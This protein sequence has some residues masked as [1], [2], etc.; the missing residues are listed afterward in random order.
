MAVTLD[1][2]VVFPHARP[3]PRAAAAHAA[4]PAEKDLRRSSCL[5]GTRLS[6]QSICALADRGFTVEQ[7][8]KIYPF[9]TPGSIAESIDLERQLQNNVRLKRVA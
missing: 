9:V 2:E 5:E 1:G 6:T 3:S 7:I 8:A 4:D